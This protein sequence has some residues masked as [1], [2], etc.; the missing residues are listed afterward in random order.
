MKLYH[1]SACC[2]EHPDT[3]HSHANLDFG[4]GFYATS[5]EDQAKKWALR[6]AVRSNKS[7]LINTYNLNESSLSKFK[8]LE[9]EDDCAWLDFICSCRRGELAYQGHDVIIGQ[10]ADDRVYDAV[11]MYFRG[12]WDA[13]TTLEAIKFYPKNNQ[14]CFVSQD[15]IDT[16]LEFTG[17]CE[18]SN[19]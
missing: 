1:G 8:V 16:L 15:A 4:P 14:Y 17:A 18:V 7:A 13:Q 11:D 10:V 19:D 3:A 5:F 12:V 2:I 9:F 6:K